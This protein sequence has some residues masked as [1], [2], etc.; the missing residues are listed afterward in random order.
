MT[1]R[2]F[3]RCLGLKGREAQVKGA[4][5]AQAGG[6]ED[7]VAGGSRAEECWAGGVS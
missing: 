6:R 7:A 4:A 3:E 2:L 5:W 1:E